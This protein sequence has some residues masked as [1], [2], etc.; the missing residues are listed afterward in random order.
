MRPLPN[1]C[2]FSQG[3]DCHEGLIQCPAEYHRRELQ[4]E[5]DHIKATMIRLEAKFDR[6]ADETRPGVEFW[7]D[8][9]GSYRSLGRVG[10]FIVT[11]GAITAAISTLFHFYSNGGPQP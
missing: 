5:I 7:R 10:K 8:M 4:Q 9:M 2:R 3:D 11:L 1:I 6:W